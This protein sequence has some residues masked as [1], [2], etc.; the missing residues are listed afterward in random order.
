MKDS[1]N[2]P[3]FVGYLD[4]PAALKRFYVPLTIVFILMSALVGYSLASQQLSSGPAQWQTDTSETI[5]GL[6]VMEPYPVVHRQDPKNPAQLESIM[7]V[8]Q[9]KMSADAFSSA[10][11]NKMVSVT[12]FPIQRGGWSMFELA[13][14]GDIQLD[15]SADP[16]L[17]P[18]LSEL[19][20]AESLGLVTLSG[21]VADSKCFLGVM[22]P[23]EG[24]VHKA[25]A[26]VCMLGGIP[27]MLLV[28]G[29]DNLKYGYLLTQSDGS[30]AAVEVANRAAEVVEITGELLK[31]GDLLYLKMPENGMSG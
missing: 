28:R 10:H 13:S 16:A 27:A 12:G 8:Q 1:A 5:T 17:L 29:A 26:E 20:R 3:F 15:T 30:D 19:A 31:K 25:C 23:G 7:L 14:I 22:K 24:K 18:T 6:L 2:K 11:N 21:E 9:G 4:M